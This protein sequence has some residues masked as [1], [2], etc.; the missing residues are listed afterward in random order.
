MY[1]I[2][3]LVHFNRLYISNYKLNSSEIDLLLIMGWF[4]EKSTVGY[5]ITCRTVWTRCLIEENPI[6]FTV[7]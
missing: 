2:I 4:E 6:I 7:S 5:I 1:M 3:G